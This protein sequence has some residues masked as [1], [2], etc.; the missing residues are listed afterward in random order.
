[1]AMFCLSLS[2]QISNNPIAV[3]VN[4]QEKYYF[5]KNGV[6]SDGQ[7]HF[8]KSEWGTPDKVYVN[9]PLQILLFYKSFPAIV[10]LDN[11][12][13]PVYEH[14][15]DNLGIGQVQLAGHDQLWCFDE[16]QRSLSLFNLKNKKHQLVYQ[17]IPEHIRDMACSIN[18]CWILSEQYLYALNPFGSLVEKK[19]HKS[20]TN[21][22]FDGKH[23]Y[24]W[25]GEKWWAYLPN[26]EMPIPL[27]ETATNPPGTLFF[28]PNYRYIYQGNQFEKQNNILIK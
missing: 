21:I 16:N 13:N 1:M 26:Q 25:D 22:Q 24:G 4:N 28:T 27:H 15:F 10:L 18:L 19:E 11:T 12:L 23:L 2:A 3:G 14:V 7:N 5:L 6:L 8:W 9:N 17:P 20:L